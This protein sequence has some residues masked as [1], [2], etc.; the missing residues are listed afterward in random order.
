MAKDKFELRIGKFATLIE[1]SNRDSASVKVQ[2]WY[3]VEKFKEQ[4]AQACNM[5]IREFLLNVKLIDPN[6][7]ENV[8]V[9][10]RAN[11]GLIESADL[12]LLDVTKE[13]FDVR[14]KF[15][16]SSTEEKKTQFGAA[17][18][19]LMDSVVFV[20]GGQHVTVT[21]L[22]PEGIAGYSHGTPLLMFNNVIFGGYDDK[23]K[24]CQI[25]SLFEHF[26]VHHTME[27]VLYT[28]IVVEFK[29]ASIKYG[30]SRCAD[31]ALVI[32]TEK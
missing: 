31:G 13:L 16:T 22:L 32:K 8:P 18:K 6:E 14:A 25:T 7:P 28:D 4:F 20:I 27:S 15:A 1:L 10:M 21:K 19:E 23:G 12:T 3:K 29:Q 11:S 24:P 9:L 17:G 26:M 2:N 30:C 5:A